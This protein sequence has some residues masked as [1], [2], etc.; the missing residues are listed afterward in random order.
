MRSIF[1]RIY[2]GM[3]VAIMLITLILALFIYSLSK[4]RITEH[5]YQNYSGTFH[6]IGEGVA[7]HNGDKRQQWLSAIERLSN[8]K[9]EHHQLSEQQLTNNQVGKLL[10]DKFLYQVDNSLASSQAFILLPEQQSYLSVTLNDFGSSLIR[11]SAFLML[12][13]LGRHQKD[14]RLSALSNLRGLFNY[15]IQ[16]MNVAELTLSSAS[17][18]TIKQGDIAVVINESGTDTPSIKAYAPIGNSQYVLVLG[19]IP[20]FDWFPLPLII[21]MILVVVGLM[22]ATS[23]YLVKPLERRLAKVDKQIEQI[24]QDKDISDSASLGYDAIGQLTNTVNAMATR[25]HKLLDAQHD[26]VRAISHEL[27]APITRVRFRLAAIEGQLNDNKEIIGIEKNLNELETLV[28]EVLTFSKLKS[29]KPELQLEEINISDFFGLMIEQQKHH[30]IAINIVT[31]NEMDN[32]VFADRRYLYRAVSNLVI[33]AIKYTKATIEIGYV[34]NDGMNTLWV[35]D[36]G[37]GIPECES[38]EIFTP[39]KRLDAS[40]DRQSGGYG[41]GLAIVQQIAHWHKGLALVER[42]RYGGAKMILQWPYLI[43]DNKVK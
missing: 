39:F 20:F 19:N 13:E 36:D 42:G 3:L 15:P 27:R 28:D 9:F 22:G 4:Y 18:R 10:H 34:C 40:R 26:M 7:R 5:I 17:Q 8:L 23:F 1:F 12:N 16:L 6:L 35:E 38:R 43:N 31:P 30:D 24:A 33:N 2:M 32:I 21:S 37:P 25:I 14:D 11:I 29:D 41:L